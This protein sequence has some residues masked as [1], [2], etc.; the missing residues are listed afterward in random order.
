MYIR[1]KD[2][3]ILVKSS[4]VQQG[5]VTSFSYSSNPLVAPCAPWR[6]TGAPT[7]QKRPPPS[8]V[9][10]QEAECSGFSRFQPCLLGTET[11]RSSPRS[12]SEL[13]MG[14]VNAMLNRRRVRPFLESEKYKSD[15]GGVFTD[16]EYWKWCYLISFFF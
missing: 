13:Q 5:W 1:L 11:L 10:S 3:E 16:N 15:Y 2:S 6:G 14:V 9:S 4:W 12:K 7:S 8:R